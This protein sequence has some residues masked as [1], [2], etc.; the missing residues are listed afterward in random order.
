MSQVRQYQLTEIIV[1]E[2]RIEHRP[3]RRTSAPMPCITLSSPRSTP[4]L[5]D[6]SGDEE[7]DH[8]EISEI[9]HIEQET[10][11]SRSQCNLATISLQDAPTQTS[12]L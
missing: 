1:K 12:R 5:E 11:A 6:D 4:E 9:E 10:R 2:E 7:E 8:N 3:W